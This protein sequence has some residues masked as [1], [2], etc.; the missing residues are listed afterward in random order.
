MPLE[1]SFKSPVL[2]LYP[3]TPVVCSQ[4]VQLPIL[5]IVAWEEQP[6]VSETVTRFEPSN[7]MKEL[8][9]YRKRRLL[10]EP[11]P[12]KAGDSSLP[13]GTRR[14]SAVSLVG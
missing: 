12:V 5:A 8:R 1:R 10:L 13:G 2:S 11:H 3:Q 4:I 9:V 7:F 6:I 14:K